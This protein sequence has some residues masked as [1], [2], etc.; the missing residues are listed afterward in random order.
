MIRGARGRVMAGTGMPRMVGALVV[1]GLLCGCSG[2]SDFGARAFAVQR[3]HEW[4]SCEQIVGL[5]TS[6][7]KQVDDLQ[8]TM[9][10]AARDPGGGFVNATAH[11]PTLASL[12]AE[13][14]LLHETIV[15]KNCTLPVPARR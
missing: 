2:D 6:Y 12:Q 3:K 8:A 14:R 13:R 9:D 1:L 4:R 15:E 7:T 5:H 10:K 11:S